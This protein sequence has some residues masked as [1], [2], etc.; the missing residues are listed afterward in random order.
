MRKKITL[1]LNS[2]LFFAIIHAQ[3]AV[4]AFYYASEMVIDS[5]GNLFVSGKNNKIIKITPDGHAY[6]FA[7]HPR[8]IPTAKMDREPMPC[9]SVSKALLLIWMTTF[10][11]LIMLLSGR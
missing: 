4:N 9:F 3:P 8:A 11:L 5:K 1:L 10:T 6:H 2:L 7:G